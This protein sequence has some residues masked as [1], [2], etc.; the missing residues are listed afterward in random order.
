M[1]SF[2]RLPALFLAAALAVAAAPAPALDFKSVGEPAVL[3]DA[4]SQ[5]AQPLFIV[6]RG[7]PVEVVVAIEGWTKVRDA[8][9]D[10]AWIEKKALA[11]RR[12]VMVRGD[13][14]QVRAQAEEKAALVFEAEKGVVL[15]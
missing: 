10:L 6:A 7:T 4:P 13:R 11:D 1:T 9:G 2:P 14:A 12:T 5:K 3:F 8:A 15:E